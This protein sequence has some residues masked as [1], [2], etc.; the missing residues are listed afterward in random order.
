MVHTPVRM[1]PL[2]L[3]RKEVWVTQSYGVSEASFEGKKKNGKKLKHLHQCFSLISP[4][5]QRE[6]SVY[7]V[8][9]YLS[10]LDPAAKGR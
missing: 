9:S 2:A 7:W 8:N 4:L 1:M 3:C 5:N 6:K 10:K